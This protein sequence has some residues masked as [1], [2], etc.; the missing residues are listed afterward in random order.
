VPHLLVDGS[1]LV[2][3]RSQHRSGNAAGDDSNHLRQVRVDRGN[4][5]AIELIKHRHSGL[6]TELADFG[7]RPFRHASA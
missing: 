3:G 5:P 6:A 2:S 1:S 4:A 7:D